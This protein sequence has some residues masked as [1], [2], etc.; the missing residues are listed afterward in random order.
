MSRLAARPFLTLLILEA[1]LPVGPIPSFVSRERAGKGTRNKVRTLHCA[2]EGHMFHRLAE[3]G[4]L[5]ESSGL[6]C[7]SRTGRSF[8]G[9]FSG[10]GGLNKTGGNSRDP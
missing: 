8:F 10:K 4:T 3:K 2:L 6:S 9:F 5:H 1:S 7:S